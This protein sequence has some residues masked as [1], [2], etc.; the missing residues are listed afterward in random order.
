MR[1]RTRTPFRNALCLRV[2]PEDETT[3]WTGL[4][5]RHGWCQRWRGHP[6]PHRSWA[7]EWNE[8]DGKSRTRR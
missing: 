4:D 3:K 6:G 2:V 1:N 5:Q 7:R 8:G